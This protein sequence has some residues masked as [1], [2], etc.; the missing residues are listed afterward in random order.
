MPMQSNRRCAV[1]RV[2]FR[3]DK[4]TAVSH[5]LDTCNYDEEYAHRHRPPG[6][7][8]DSVVILRF[9]FGQLLESDATYKIATQIHA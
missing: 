9:G 4:D 5:R 6:S 8:S 3:Y 2:P 1:C 7:W